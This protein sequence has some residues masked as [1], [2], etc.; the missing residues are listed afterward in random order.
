M[1]KFRTEQ[2]NVLR[3]AQNKPYRL[4]CL[5]SLLIF[6]G[7]LWLAKLSGEKT[8]VHMRYELARQIETVSTRISVLAARYIAT[9]P[10]FTRSHQY[11]LMQLW[12][13]TYAE[14]AGFDRLYMQFIRNGQL[15]SG[16]DSLYP[17]NSHA[18][19]PGTVF[20]NPDS[21][22]FEVFSTGQTTVRGPDK[23]RFKE[24]VTATAAIA[25]PLTRQVYLAVRLDKKASVWR[26]EVRKAQWMP[27]C[28]ALALIA[29]QA[30]GFILIQIRARRFHNDQ[31]KLHHIETVICAAV[32]LI[33]TLSATFYFHDID[34]RLRERS[35]DVLANTKA[36]SIAANFQYVNRGLNIIA[37]ALGIKEHTSREEFRI[38][39]TPF[40]LTAP[41]HA[42]LWVPE[43]PADKV[44]GFEASVRKDDLP[45]FSIKNRIHTKAPVLS[46]TNL[47]YPVLYQASTP[48]FE[49][50]IGY[51]LASIPSAGNAIS[52]AI[53]SRWVNATD[54][55]ELTLGSGQTSGIFLFK[56]ISEKHQKG[57]F[58][59]ILSPNVL[60]PARYSFEKDATSLTV[61]LFQLQEGTAPRWITSSD[62][63][64]EPA[65]WGLLKNG[66]HAAIPNFLYGKS[67]MLVITPDRQWL[68]ENYFLRAKV[69]LFVG[70][71]LSV[72]LTTLIAVLSNRHILLEKIIRQRTAE[73][74][75][76]EQRLKLATAAADIG[77]WD[78]DIVNDQLIWNERMY[79][80][81]GI[82]PEEFDG[83]YQTWHKHVHPGDLQAAFT[84]VLEAEQGKNEFNT[85]FRIIRSN[86]DI[87]H[88]RAFGK[89]IHDDNGV[90]LRMIGVNYDITDHKHAAQQAQSQ[91]NELNRWHQVT[92]GREMRILELKRE[93][94]ELLQRNGEPPRYA[95]TADNLQKDAHVPSRL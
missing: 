17:D 55:C 16:T 72:F 94:N 66:L 74:R 63:R 19:P 56:A 62:S 14:A 21:R 59:C 5:S 4:L 91:L 34:K 1:N 28:V 58:V 10:D 31:S 57:L 8:D 11:N 18:M 81:Y 42:C 23:D 15:I 80:I 78:R 93:I 20:T 92:L 88:I 6:I 95:E 87:R 60:S 13:K 9:T 68:A 54:P 44:T 67:Y 53:A 70:I 52:N 85:E 30:S 29:V 26:A 12:T 2:Q 90:P 25:D 32:T 7:G 50:L 82:S 46:S 39:T 77:V 43:V 22:D 38:L 3:I 36:A 79:Q 84:A 41:V 61:D 69:A 27:V 47:L 86:G 89:V 35:F 71:I 83:T 65:D 76:S 75:E 64:A 49:N 40:L 51:N 33:L 24:Y 37:S 48:P 73:L 45:D